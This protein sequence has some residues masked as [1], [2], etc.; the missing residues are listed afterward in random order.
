MADCNQL[1]TEYHY[2]TS[3]YADHHDDAGAV[4]FLG[5]VRPVVQKHWNRH[6]A[7]AHIHR[8][9]LLLTN[10]M[11][12]GSCRLTHH[13]NYYNS[14]ATCLEVPTYHRGALVAC[15]PSTR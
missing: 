9:D 15:S 13:I 7:M 2:H 8:E 4:S 3:M 6:E 11:L 1:G 5:G 14:A 12:T 10:E